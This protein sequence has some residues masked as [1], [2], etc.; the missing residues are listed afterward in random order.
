LLDQS[1]PKEELYM[2]LGF[3]RESVDAVA[4]DWQKIEKLNRIL[5]RLAQRKKTA[6]VPD[7]ALKESKVAWKLAT[8]CQAA[9]HR[10]VMLADGCTREWNCQNFLCAIVIARAAMESAALFLDFEDR[11]LAM[12]DASDLAGIDKLLMHVT[13]AT[14]LEHWLA[15]YPAAMQTELKAI[16]V[17]TM[18]DRLDKNKLEGARR[19]YDYLSEMCHPNS[20]GQYLAF[21]TLDK[22]TAV[23]TFSDL[24]GLNR[25]MFSCVVGALYMVAAID[26]ALTR[27]ELLE[28]R[29]VALNKAP[30]GRDPTPND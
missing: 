7:G 4:D 17:L 26:D 21:A 25:G 30:S 20:L 19:F 5:N 27:L 29:I 18:I 16:N 12:C 11:I 1:A 13:H 8:F 6:I 14:R 2:S 3:S 15:D 10:V 22:T 24:A 9:L 28:P 23:E